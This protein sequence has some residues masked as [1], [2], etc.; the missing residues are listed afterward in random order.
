MWWIE[1]ICKLYEGKQAGEPLILHGCRTCGKQYP[2]PR[3]WNDETLAA[4]AEREKEYSKCVKAGHQCDWQYEYFM[5]RFGWV[6]RSPETQQ[7]VRRFKR[8][9]VFIPKKSKKTPSEAAEALYVTFGEGEPGNHGYLAAKDGGQARLAAQ[10]V[11]KMYEQFEPAFKDEFDCNKNL[12]QLT[13]AKSGSTLAPISSS[14]SRSQ[15]SKEGLNGSVFIDELH[16]VDDNTVA[17]LRYA[18]ISRDEAVFDAFTTAGDDPQSIGY[19]LVEYGKTVNAGDVDDDEFLFLGYYAPPNIS[20][21]ELKANPL[22]YGMMANPAWGHTIRE[23]EYMASFQQA[24]VSPAAW[25]DFKKYRLN[26]W[27][28]AAV[29]WLPVGAWEANARDYDESK[30]LG[31]TCY[32]G[33]DLSKTTD[34]TSLALVFPEDDGT[35][36]LLVY[37]WLPE[38]TA[39]KLSREVGYLKWAQDNWI[40]LTPGD[41]VDYQFVRKQINDIREKFDLQKLAFDGT[42]AEQLMQRLAEEDGMNVEDQIKFPQTIMEFAGPTAAFERNV[43]SEKLHNDGNPLLAW[44]AGHTMVKCD[45]NQNKRPVK[46]KHG[47]IRTIDGVVASIMAF[48]MAEKFKDDLVG[49]QMILI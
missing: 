6:K 31:R 49:P 33:L 30:L 12:M 35:F 11:F 34:T 27:Q 40:T 15:R 41:V 16:V 47:D 2:I 39:Q 8:A 17:T 22:K 21:E 37:Y 42:Y 28:K 18:G 25:A 3:E 26:I 43:I 32:G 7:W 38:A 20:D 9:V 36:K 48:G 5:R 1:R 46:Q 10:H 19:Q 13:H 29:V 23:S 45:P 4:M 24:L 44:Q 14:D